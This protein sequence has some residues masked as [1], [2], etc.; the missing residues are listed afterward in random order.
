MFHGSYVLTVFGYSFLSF[1]DGP[2]ALAADLATLT[3]GEATVEAI[4]QVVEDTAP[5]TVPAAE[6][7]TPTATPPTVPITP[8]TAPPLY[9]YFKITKRKFW[10]SYQ[11]VV[12]PVLCK[13]RQR[14][15]L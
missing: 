4:L 1:D 10:T 5:P 2:T 11:R 7:T 8:P 6:P 14:L 13:Q 9:Y 3:T 12:H 15:H